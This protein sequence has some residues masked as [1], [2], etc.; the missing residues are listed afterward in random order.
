MQRKYPHPFNLR[1]SL[2]RKRHP[3]LQQQ[4][5]QQQPPPL[6]TRFLLT[7]WQR[8]A[9][10]LKARR[11]LCLALR[12]PRETIFRSNLRRL[13]QQHQQHHKQG[14]HNHQSIFGKLTIFM[15]THQVNISETSSAEHILNGYRFCLV[16]PSVSASSIVSSSN[17]LATAPSYI[18]TQSLATTLLSAPTTATSSSSSTAASSDLTGDLT[19]SVNWNGNGYLLA[20]P[21]PPSSAS[22]A[23]FPSP[24]VS[25][26]TPGPVQ[27]PHASFSPAPGS[28][29]HSASRCI[30]RPSPEP[31]SSASN[32]A[33]PFSLYF[34]LDYSM[35][36]GT[37]V[38]SDGTGTTS[39]ESSWNYPQDQPQFGSSISSNDF[40]LYDPFH[41]GTGLT[42]PSSMPKSLLT[43]E[44]SGKF[45][46]AFSLTRER[47]FRPL[48]PSDRFPDLCD[49]SIGN[50]ASD[51]DPF[52][53]E[54]EA[55]T[56]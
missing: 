45:Q 32:T 39:Q 53:K 2:N 16:V 43:N 9:S 38:W 4:Q 8:C 47:V 46:Q 18:P 49:V 30:Q 54:I 24:S 26:L 36:P 56:K 11:R 51:F 20:T 3:P 12:I 23:L 25:S 27:R 28:M 15:N 42:I 33:G 5:Q 19:S 55:F 21:P 17:L 41:S 29:N 14:P 31:R 37:S 7:R 10:N 52:E 22:T 34:P 1:L 44:F 6:P 48:C 35:D 50:V 13:I 40:P